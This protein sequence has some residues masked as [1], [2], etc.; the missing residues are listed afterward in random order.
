METHGVDAYLVFH[1]D[2]H[3]SEYLAPCDERCRYIS[4]FS[5]SN[6]ICFA[7][8][9]HALMWTDGRYFLAAEKQL[10]QGWKLMKMDIGEKPYFEW[11]A[12]NV[13][14][15]ARIG[16]DISQLSA[17]AFKRRSDYFKE[18]QIELVPVS[19]NLVDTVWAAD[20]PARPTEKVFTLPVEYT[21]SSVQTN[22]D[23]VKDK[24]ALKK[25]NVLLI[26][27]LDD[28][29]WLLN[30]RGNDIKFN[31]VF[32]SYALFHAPSEG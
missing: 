25:V 11:I 15:P 7:N 12:D 30:L 20:R 17:V 23:R 26:S 28:I 13:S 8:K 21:G 9:D 27:T 29:A 18:K 16:V 1:G 22:Y 6:A 10:E 24:M 4:G 2:N 19:V 5:G 31:P 3:D 14:K 32:F